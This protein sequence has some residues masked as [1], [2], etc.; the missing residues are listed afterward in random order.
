[1]DIIN[2]VIEFLKSGTVSSLVV[3]LLM[4]V[5]FWLGKTDVVKAGSTIEL[6]LNSIKKVLDFVKG[7]IGPKA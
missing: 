2:K 6:I 4:C 5:E 1:M 3:F 7:I